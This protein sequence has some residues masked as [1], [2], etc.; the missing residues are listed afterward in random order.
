M[1]TYRLLTEDVLVKCPLLIRLCFA[2][3]VFQLKI[4][5]DNILEISIQ[6][7]VGILSPLIL[8]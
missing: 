8:D 5:I 1:A 7:I 6:K 3:T 2:I 4:H